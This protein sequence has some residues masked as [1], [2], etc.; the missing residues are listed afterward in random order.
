[1]SKSSS[2]GKKVNFG[3]QFWR[4]IVHPSEEGMASEGV[5][6]EGVASEGMALEGM[7]LEC[8]VVAASKLTDNIS[9]SRKQRGE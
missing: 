5:A 1:M 8:M 7:A 2:T 3:F 4:D 6:S 9:S